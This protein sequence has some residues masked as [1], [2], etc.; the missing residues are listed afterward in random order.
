MLH[1]FQDLVPILVLF[2][3]FKLVWSSLYRRI[4]VFC[5]F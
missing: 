2:E 5:I 3:Y 1:T 4:W